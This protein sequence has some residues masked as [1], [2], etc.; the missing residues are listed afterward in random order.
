MEQKVWYEELGVTKEKMKVFSEFIFQVLFP[1]TLMP[2][3]SDAYL[4]IK[5]K[6]EDYQLTVDDLAFVI[7]LFYNHIYDRM[8]TWLKEE[9]KRR[10]EGKEVGNGEW[11][12]KDE[13]Y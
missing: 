12:R 4:Y 6:I 9:I 2:L 5:K 13:G 10:S 7:V 11:R 8:E 1:A 3:K